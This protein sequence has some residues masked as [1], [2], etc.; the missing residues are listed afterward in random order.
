MC[1]TYDNDVQWILNNNNNIHSIVISK[2]N[3][4]NYFLIHRRLSFFS[5]GIVIFLKQ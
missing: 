3:V 5:I 1:V 2:L 4:Q